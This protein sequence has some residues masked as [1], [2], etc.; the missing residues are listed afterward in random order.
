MADGDKDRP[1]VTQSSNSDGPISPLDI[2]SVS[3]L[4]P[5]PR[6]SIPV[7]APVSRI[8]PSGDPPSPAVARIAG[9]MEGQASRDESLRGD[10]ARASERKAMGGALPEPNRVDPLRGPQMHHRDQRLFV[11]L[12]TWVAIIVAVIGG[13][14]GGSFGGFPHWGSALCVGGLFG[15]YAMTLHL[16]EAKPRV[17][18]AQSVSATLMVV[19]VLT[20]IFVGWQTW[21]AFHKPVVGYTQAQLDDATSKAT[22]SIK[23]AVAGSPFGPTITEKGPIDGS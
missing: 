8:V 1:Q 16:L 15:A 10:T 18:T 17:P 2:R 14:I 4:A 12:A 21:L 23:A 3:P 5:P 20:W 7:S 11:V 19:A 13:G 6:R 22:S 9:I